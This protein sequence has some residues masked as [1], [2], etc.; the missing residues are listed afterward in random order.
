[1]IKVNS[2]KVE[3]DGN[4]IGLI[5]DLTFIIKAF[6][7]Y[8]LIDSEQEILRIYKI[9]KMSP[10]ELEKSAMEKLDSMDIGNALALMIASERYAHE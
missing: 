1:M 4:E 10:E 3:I 5:A 9:A 2:S 8:G 6:I 7:H